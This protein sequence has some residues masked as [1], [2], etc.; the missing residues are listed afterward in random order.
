MANVR[1]GSVADLFNHSS[2]AA[3]LERIAGVLEQ[4]V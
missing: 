4:V 2:A 1:F 3:A